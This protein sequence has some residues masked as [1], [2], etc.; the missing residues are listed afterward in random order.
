M[1]RDRV[2]VCLGQCNLIFWAVKPVTRISVLL[3]CHHFVIHWPVL[4]SQNAKALIVYIFS[5][6]GTLMKLRTV[7]EREQFSF[8]N[9]FFLCLPEESISP[10]VNKDRYCILITHLHTSIH[11]FLHSSVFLKRLL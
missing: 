6:R 7:G 2:N 10:V 9:S 1:Q 4:D 8:S 5:Q 3:F 11:A